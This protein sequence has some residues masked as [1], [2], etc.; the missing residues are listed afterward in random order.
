M[1][2][3]PANTRL[4]TVTLEHLRNRLEALIEEGADK[5]PPERN[6]ALELGVSR[7]VLR[8]ALSHLE[9]EGSIERTR[10]RGTVILH[11][12]A[13]VWQ[14]STNLKRYTSPAELM[15]T[16]LALEPAIAALAAMNAT[17]KDIEDMQEYIDKGRA[18][19]DA[20][21]WER[22]DSALHKSISRSTCNSLLIRFTEVLDEA[23][24]QTAWGRLRRAALTIEHRQI[25]VQQHELIVAAIADRDPEQAARAMRQHL[26]SVRGT[27][28][29]RLDE[30][31]H[32]AY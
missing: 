7:R 24:K 2:S 12:D 17:S 23:R 5:L 3:F 13:S 8:E 25:S 20:A 21:A 4:V 16:R 15:E 1:S 28:L 26:T 27:L 32:S 29:V 30:S 31:D 10:G 14:P 9:T 19:V 6:L 22:W 18:A 11:S